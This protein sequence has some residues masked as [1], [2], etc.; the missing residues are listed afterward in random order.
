MNSNNPKGLNMRIAI[1]LLIGLLTSVSSANEYRAIFWNLESGESDADTIADQMVAKGPIDFWGLSEVPDQEFLDTLSEKLSIATNV[2][3]EVKLSEDPGSS[4]KL[5]IIFNADRLTS[6][7]YSGTHPI[8]DLG[9]NF[10]EV[11]TVQLSAGLRPS[12]GIQLKGDDGQSVVVLVNHFKAFGGDENEAKRKTQAEATNVF[13]AMTPGIPVVV[14]G[15]HNMPLQPGGSGLTEPAFSVLDEQ[16][17]YL[18]PANSGNVGSFKN[19]SVLDSVWLANDLAAFESSVTILNRNGNTPAFTATFSDSA[20]DTDHRPLL[21]LIE[22]DAEER[23]ESL[24]EDIALLEDVLARMKLTLQA[25]ESAR[26]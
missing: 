10:F 21:L 15:D 13:I 17:D 7:P 8:D 20:D 18:V 9:S 12:L 23:I 26:Q 25:L 6:E 19:G 2:N 1:F 22:S 16:C 24:K 11:D 4:D 3:Y 14:G 5:A